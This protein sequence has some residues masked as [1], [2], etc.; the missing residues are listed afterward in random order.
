MLIRLARTYLAP[1]QRPLVL[2]VLLQF[3]GTLGALYLPKLNA[4]I[5]DQ[6]VITGDT[7]YIV[8]TG[9]VMLVVAL[10]QV[11]CSIGAVWF[12]AKT[13]MSFGRDVRAAIFHR[14]GTF[15]QREVQDFG[16]PSL[17]TRETNDVQQ[18]Q[19]LVLMSCTLMVMA[20]IMMVGGIVMAIH[21]DVGLS[22]LV[23]VM[24]PVLAFCL[25]L[26]IR[27]MVPSF[28]LMQSCIDEV[29]RL[30]R[31][32][33][34]GVRVVRAFVREPLET[35]RFETANGDLTTVAVRAGRYQALMFPTVM[36]VANVASVGVLWFGGHRVD[37]GEMQVGALTAYLSYLMQI[38]M[39]VMMGT[40]MMMMIPRSAVCA[41]RIMEV[42]RT[43][44]SVPVPDEPVTD[45]RQRGTLRLDRV[46]F[47]YPGA[48]A[49]VLCDLSFEA[50][51][52]QTVA[53]IGST[54]AGKSTLVNLVPRLFDVTGGSLE[55]DGVD[56]RRLDRERL[57]SVL[58]LVPQKAYLFS[59]T[60]R[61]NLLHGKPGATDEELWEALEIAQA[62]DFVRAMPEGLD[63]AI[64]QG[65][66]NV[67]GGQRQRLAIARA[68][69]RRPE[70]YLF[71]D[72]FSALDLAT[73]ARLRAALR[74]V[75][76]D[77]TV[78]I[79]AQ[80]VS[81]IR[82][83]DLILVLEDGAVVGRGR[84]HELLASCATYQEIVASQLSAEEAA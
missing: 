66:T 80:R 68:V 28:R 40:F 11:A 63:A 3:I 38:V 12:G 30:L 5:I 81:T 65:G 59:G 46:E 24:V 48:D 36:L 55:V 43:T 70:I 47:S 6:G 84:H 73:D 76:R 21:V 4:D 49:P 19:M 71:D 22:W 79:V 52:G 18:V 23:A 29:N 1:Y 50:V 44:T 33:I 9:A 60:V 35:E 26:I 58:G 17:I 20:P 78:L 67:S 57:W 41:D 61:S 77:A 56:V 54:G 2:V 51:P 15:S 64:A 13:A 31:E 14:V 62:A 8:R 74:P 75:T 37:S 69:V 53:V 72:S 10:V 27:R 32:Q 45:L 34:T 25:A 16:A 39:S 42:L 83:A 7:G 82:D